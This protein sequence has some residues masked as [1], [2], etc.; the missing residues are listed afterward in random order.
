MS[1][2]IR[3]SFFDHMADLGLEVEA[4]DPP[5]LFLEA[6]RAVLAWLGDPVPQGNPPPPEESVFEG[7]D[8]GDLLVDWLGEV[9]YR[10]QALGQIPAP[11]AALAF[12]G[13]RLVARVAWVPID[14]RASRI[15]REIKAVTYHRLEVTGDEATGY[16][17][18]LVLDV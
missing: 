14:S 10:A 5:S 9:I 8:L 12:D 13:P 7:R 16:R 3:S 1:R 6:A 18:V 2:K 4:P 17:A 11:D 15:D